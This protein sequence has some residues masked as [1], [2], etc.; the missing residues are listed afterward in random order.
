M[1]KKIGIIIESPGKIQKIKNIL[2][3]IDKKNEYIVEATVGHIIDLS[4]EKPNMYGID[5]E[6]GFKPNY[7]VINDKK[8]VV[9]KIKKLYQ[10]VDKLIIASDMDREGEFIAYSITDI[11]GIDVKDANRI[12]YDNITESALKDA[13]D[14]ISDIDIKRVESQQTRRMLDRLIGFGISAVS[15]KCNGFK[16]NVGRVLSMVVKLIVDKETEIDDDLKKSKSSFYKC[17]GLFN[18]DPD[19]KKSIIKTSLYQKSAKK[20]SDS[21]SNKKNEDNDNEEQLYESDHEEDANIKGMFKGTPAKLAYGSELHPAKE[22][23]KFLKSC[24]DSKFKVHLVYDKPKSR[25]PSS[26][27]ITTTL[28]Q[29]ASSKFGYTPKTTM[30]LAQDLYNKGHITYMRTDSPSLSKEAT[31]NIKNYIY[32]NFT[33]KYYE[34]REFKSKDSAAQEAHECIRPSY[35]DK[36]TIDDVTLDR[37]HHKLYDLIWKKTIASQMKPAQFTLTVIQISI[38]E[39]EDYYFEGSVEKQIFDGYL[40]LYNTKSKNDD[41]DD[42]NKNGERQDDINDAD[43]IEN[44]NSIKIPSSGDKLKMNDITA[45]QELPK[46]PS[47]YNNT[48]LVGK[49]KKLKIGRPGTTA[50]IIEN[51]EKYNY[52]K[53]GNVKGSQLKLYILNINKKSEEINIEDKLVMFGSEKN[54]YI[55]TENAFKVMEFLN[56]YFSKLFNYDFN[57]QL[58]NKLDMIAIGKD[59]WK[60]VMTECFEMFN[61]IVEKLNSEYKTIRKDNE[62]LLGKHP[63]LDVDVIVS[64]GKYGPFVRI[65]SSDDIKKCELASIPSSI[66]YKKITL[67][68]ALKLFIKKYPKEIGNLDDIP[69]YLNLGKYG[70]YLNYNSKNYNINTDILINGHDNTEKTSQK[71]NKRKDKDDSDYES[72][73]GSEDD[74]K[75]NNNKRIDTSNLSNDEIEKYITEKKAIEI[76]NYT[77]KSNILEFTHK[78]KK[79]TV[80]NGKFGPYVKIVTNKNKKIHNISIN[81]LLND[82]EIKLEDLKKINPDDFVK[83]LN[84][85]SKSTSDYKNKNKT[86][87]SYV[88]SKSDANK[89]KSA[90]KKISST[91]KK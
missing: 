83:L 16:A 88:S 49:M 53:M 74:N 79:Y 44:D 86:E 77:L 61:P 7:I 37:R 56:Q 5:I 81:K 11:L 76:I 67:E 65:C 20:S 23:K 59:K 46:P 48:S 12:I 10:N 57:I 13:L 85:I 90:K 55:P 91:N 38:S 30:Q 14:N 64:V 3:K 34:H 25:N 31:E 89:P 87:K 35:I 50:A 15:Q 82:E 27:Y 70:F 18:T 43:A 36:E 24:L 17:I 8:E 73:N 42:E 21:I 40:T 51:A 84:N 26:P 47:R 39:E 41:D 54:R 33:K 19:N 1:S 22:V 9:K 78:D 6:N 2:A 29:D 66:N 62:I 63:N 58:E 80:L 60:R 45:T 75:I 32:D 71:S 4:K 68:E 52:I 72:D 69:I 28:Q